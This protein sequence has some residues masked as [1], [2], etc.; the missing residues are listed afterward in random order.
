MASISLDTD[1]NGLRV[2]LLV[3]DDHE[4]FRQLVVSTIQE[5]PQIQIVG[6]AADGLHAVRKAEQLQP[7]LILLDIG[8][9]GQNGLDA[10]RQIRALCPESKILF[11]SQVT[12]V[13]V[14]QLALK[15][16]GA[17]YVVKTEAGRDLLDAIEAII[18]GETFFSPGLLDSDATPV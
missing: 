3:V 10:A 16:G 4:K 12:S 5:V 2:R 15:A 1:G 14:V 13:D 9:P 8:L 11:V 17:G 18:R 6:E 7:D